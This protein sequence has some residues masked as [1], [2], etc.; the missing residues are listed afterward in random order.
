MKVLRKKSTFCFM[1]KKR[2]YILQFTLKEPWLLP[3]H[4]E[5]YSKADC[6]LWGWLF[7]YFGWFNEPYTEKPMSVLNN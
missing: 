5:H 2:D 6:N 4:E 3:R 7:V 1:T